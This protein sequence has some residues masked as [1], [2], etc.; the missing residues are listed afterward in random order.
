MSSCKFFAHTLPATARPRRVRSQSHLLHSF[1]A[2]EP[3]P[4]AADFAL[5]LAASDRADEYA[6]QWSTSD[7]RQR[8]RARI[9]EL[10]SATY[11]PLGYTRRTHLRLPSQ[12]AVVKPSERVSELE[13]CWFR[14][15]TAC[16]PDLPLSLPLSLSPPPPSPTPERRYWLLFKRVSKGVFRAPEE[17][18]GFLLRSLFLMVLAGLFFWQLR[19]DQSGATLRVNLLG[20]I[21]V[22]AGLSAFAALPATFEFRP[23]LYRERA[24]GMYNTAA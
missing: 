23:V 6:E 14:F 12:Y 8:V 15:A 18:T 16:A 21:T 10:N 24:E 9:E 20:F 7:A 11:A 5:S 19:H 3:T 17:L 1:F 13:C 2:H 22:Y 4:N